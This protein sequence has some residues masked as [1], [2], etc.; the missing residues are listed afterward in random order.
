LNDGATIA[1]FTLGVILLTFYFVLNC[2]NPGKIIH[3]EEINMFRL[4]KKS[5]FGKVCFKCNV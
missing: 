2:S 3:P 1:L 5:V 4:M